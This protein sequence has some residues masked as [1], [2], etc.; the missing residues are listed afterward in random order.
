MEIEQEIEKVLKEWIACSVAQHGR[1]CLCDLKELVSD[2]ARLVT[3][4]GKQREPS[5]EELREI[6]RTSNHGHGVGAEPMHFWEGSG[7]AG[8]N[9]LLDK[10]QAWSRGES[11]KVCPTCHQEVKNEAL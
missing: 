6:I 1:G 9:T 10:I 2:L 3:E 11:K 5:R 4:G 7:C 8:C